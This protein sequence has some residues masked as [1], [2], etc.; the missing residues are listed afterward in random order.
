VPL[1]ITLSNLHRYCEIAARR[2]L[3][4]V[5]RVA[6]FASR[7]WRQ[8]VIPVSIFGTKMGI[9]AHFYCLR[10]IFVILQLSQSP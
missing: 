8:S 4:M 1:G 9:G 2:R 3:Y 5:W 7:E 10:T 6:R